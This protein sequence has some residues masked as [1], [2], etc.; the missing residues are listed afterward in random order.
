MNAVFLVEMAEERLQPGQHRVVLLFRAGRPGGRAKGEPDRDAP[1]APGECVVN[2]GGQ[3]TGCP[4][5]PDRVEDRVV[6]AA[7]VAQST[8]MD[9]PPNRLF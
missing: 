6:R 3:C 4:S 8:W 1:G 5:V 7:V 9:R 2:L